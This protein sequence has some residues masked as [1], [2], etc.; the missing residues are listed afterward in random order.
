MNYPEEVK[1]YK[2]REALPTPRK[3]ALLVIDMQRYF[4]QVAVLVIDNVLG[5]IEECR[6]KAIK[7]AFTRHGH[8][9]P[10]LDGGMLAQWWYC[11]VKLN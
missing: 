9:D 4:Q 8:H 1:R 5:L 6:R 7:T 11:Q 10:K 3:S 2:V